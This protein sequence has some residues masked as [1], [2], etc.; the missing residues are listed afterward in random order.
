MV[1]KESYWRYFC[2]Q[3]RREE[4]NQ[5]TA[6]KEMEQTQSGREVFQNV[7]GRGKW[8]TEGQ[9]E[10]VFPARPMGF[11]YGNQQLS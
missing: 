8:P 4:K 2:P 11:T 3:T 10:S 7:G 9:P 1:H 6:G 5:D